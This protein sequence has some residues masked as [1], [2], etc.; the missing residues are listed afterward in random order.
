MGGLEGGQQ[1]LLGHFLHLAFH[2]HDVLVGGAH[3]QVHIGLLQLFKGGVDDELSV[4]AGHTH[5][6]DGASEGDVAHGQCGRGGQPGQCV[7]HVY[8][9]GR[10]EDDVD[11]YFSVEIVGEEGAQGA[12]YQ[13]AGQ[14]FSI[15]GT[16]FAAGEAAG[17]TSERGILFFI[18]YLKGH[19]VCTGN[20]IFCGTNSS[21]QHGVAHAQHHSTIC[22]FCQLSRLERDGSA[23]GQLDSLNNGVNHK[24]S[25]VSIFS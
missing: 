19:E 9:V 16:A 10:E 21:Q 23:I 12:V 25:V 17:E 15:R 13:A 14:D 7:W 5:F 22:L 4:D 3:H 6:G 2:H 18:L 20:C 24:K 11:I 8:A 1:V